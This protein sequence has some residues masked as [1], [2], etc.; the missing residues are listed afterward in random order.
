MCCNLM[1]SAQDATKLKY[2]WHLLF[3]KIK[4]EQSD[5]N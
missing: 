2:E 1:I 4:R 3:P 5:K